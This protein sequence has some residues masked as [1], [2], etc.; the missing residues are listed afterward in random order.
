MHM[1]LNRFIFSILALF[2]L[3]LWIQGSSQGIPDTAF[4]QSIRVQ[5][6]G[7][8]AGD[9]TFS[10]YLPDNRTLWLFGDSFIGTVNE[11]SSLAPGAS[12]IRNCAIVQEDEIMFALY[13][14]SFGEPEDFVS[15]N[16]PDSTWFWPEHGMVEND[17]LK[18]I[19]SEFGKTDGTPGWNFEYLNAWI[20]YLSYPGLEYINQVKLPY[21]EENGVMYGDRLLEHDG[22]TY[23]F[24]RK[25]VSPDYNIPMPHIA[26]VPSGDILSEW[27]FYDGN[28]WTSNSSSSKKISDQPVSQQYGV[29]KYQDKFVMI[30]QE[31]WLGTHIYSMVSNQPYGPWSNLEV[32]YITPLPY[33]DMFTYN[34][35]PHSQFND[36][37]ELLVSYNSNGDFF[38]IFNNIELYRPRFLRIPYSTIH[39]SFTS[40]DIIEQNERSE[41]ILYPNP[42][43]NSL[44]VKIPDTEVTFEEAVLFN[45]R[46]EK[47]GVFTISGISYNDNYIKVPTK[48]LAT[49]FYIIN[50]GSSFG[51]FI[52]K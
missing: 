47:V 15:T 35:Y 34:A 41:L 36:N 37:N 7:W 23:I 4:N 2:F 19:F 49:G 33:E 42:S 28:H 16:Y 31:I 18:I 50:I 17:T 13:N 9:A 40:S 22:Y 30:T 12:M 48:N 26:R 25:P 10:I 3:V 6:G 52:H 29:F 11:D 46:G 14:G 43:D 51:R 32:I 21:F 45:A 5:N 1:L 39:P 8:V 27:E 24:G 38:E 20:I 44:Y